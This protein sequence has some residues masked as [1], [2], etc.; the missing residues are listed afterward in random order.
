MKTT[1]YRS[2]KRGNKLEKLKKIKTKKNKRARKAQKKHVGGGEISTILKGNAPPINRIANFVLTQEDVKNY[3]RHFTLPTD[4]ALSAFQFMGI[5]TNKETEV[6]RIAMYRLSGLWDL[7]MELIGAIKTGFNF[8]FQKFENVETWGQFL[9][10][11]LPIGTAVVCGYT[12]HLFIMFHGLD[13]KMYLVDP[14]L[15][16][17]IMGDN[18][19]VKVCELSNPNCYM[20]L[21]HA[22]P[23]FS[24]LCSSSERIGVLQGTELT[25]HVNKLLNTKLTQVD[26]T[27]NYNPS[28]TFIKDVVPFNDDGTGPMEMSA[29]TRVVE[30]D[31]DD[32]DL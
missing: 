29:D 20:Y 15:P 3:T 14:Q 27:V 23:P 2:L 8:E 18:P 11:Y 5:L 19:H 1:K 7:Q 24:V 22:P 16:L 28:Q 25:T 17:E 32:D 26:T 9:T 10:T 4:C 21:S 13:N 6:L 30:L 31:D 12:G